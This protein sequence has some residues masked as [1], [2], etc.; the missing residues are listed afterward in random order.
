MPQKH[1][2]RPRQRS[3]DE[4]KNNAPEAR[5]QHRKFAIIAKSVQRAASFEFGPPLSQLL[6]RPGCAQAAPWCRAAAAKYIDLE[7][8]LHKERER[9]RSPLLLPLQSHRRRRRSRGTKGGGA[10]RLYFV[11]NFRKLQ[12]HR[13]VHPEQLQLLGEQ[14]RAGASTRRRRRLRHRRGCERRGPTRV[15][16]NFAVH[17]AKFAFQG[18]QLVMDSL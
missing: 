12:L 17:P 4:S 2:S 14:N 18:L 3:P 5:S 8:E 10:M 7:S 13:K 9:L 1:S 15:H 6:M 16:C 11:R